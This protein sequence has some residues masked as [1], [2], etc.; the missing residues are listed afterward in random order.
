[1]AV[2]HLVVLL[3]VLLAA[4]PVPV[5]AAAPPPPLATAAPPLFLAPPPADLP[6]H[7]PPH[8]SSGGIQAQDGEH[9]QDAL[10]AYEGAT[11]LGGVGQKEGVQQNTDKW[12]SEKGGSSLPEA[13]YAFLHILLMS[14]SICQLPL[15]CTQLYG[16][17]KSGFF[18]KFDFFMTSHC[19]MGRRKTVRSQTVRMHYFD[20][21]RKLSPI[22]W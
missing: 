6:A 14:E 10:H 22:S 21:K 7:H 13:I 18:V 19:L 2:V 12:I 11:S 3:L 16:T 15:Y 17:V 9:R 8:P 20:L 1:M 4:D 5:L